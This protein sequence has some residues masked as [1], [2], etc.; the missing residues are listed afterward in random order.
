MPQAPEA[1]L[2]LTFVQ[3]SIAATIAELERADR[4]IAPL[5]GPVARALDS[6]R[7]AYEGLEPHILTP[8]LMG[9]IPFGPEFWVFLPYQPD[10]IGPFGTEEAAWDAWF[11]RIEKPVTANDSSLETP[12]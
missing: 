9:V 8:P 2:P 12:Q 7:R 11:D 6:A 3:A 4:R 1:P 5:A 10:G